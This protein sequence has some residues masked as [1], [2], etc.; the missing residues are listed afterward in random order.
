MVILWYVLIWRVGSDEGGGLSC[1]AHWS[2]VSNLIFRC[3]QLLLFFFFK[4]L[5]A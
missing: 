5:S 3:L 1:C 2:A 4:K